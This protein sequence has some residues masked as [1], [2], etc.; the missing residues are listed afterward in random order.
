MQLAQSHSFVVNVS[1]MVGLIRELQLWFVPLWQCNISWEGFLLPEHPAHT[2]TQISVS[3]DSMI[4]SGCGLAYLQ[5]MLKPKNAKMSLASKPV[6]LPSPKK[7]HTAT[8]RLAFYDG[9]IVVVVELS[10]KGLLNVT[11]SNPP[12]VNREKATSG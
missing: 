2:C 12:A 8:A 10:W 6:H 1:L 4:E 7:N 9:N 5:Q 11:K 3:V